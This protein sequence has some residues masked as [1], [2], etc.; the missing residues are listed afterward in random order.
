MI[1]TACCNLGFFSVH[2]LYYVM[3]FFVYF[4]DIIEF[5]YISGSSKVFISDSC[6]CISLLH[7]ILMLAG[8]I[9][10]SKRSLALWGSGEV[11]QHW[12]L[13]LKL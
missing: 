7:Y 3:F 1:K 6:F 4:K 10:H 2:P 8:H 5:D 13:A 12:S 11:L 9:I